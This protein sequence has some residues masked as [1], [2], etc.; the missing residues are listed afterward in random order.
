VTGANGNW[1]RQWSL[2]AA[3]A[4]AIV[5]RFGAELRAIYQ[6]RD[7]TWAP[8]FGPGVFAG[9]D[10]VLQ[11]DTRFEATRALHLRTGAL[12]D[13]IHIENSGYQPYPT[14]S[15]RK[16]SRAYLGLEARFG[17]VTVEVIEGIELDHEPYEVWFVHDKGFLHLQTTF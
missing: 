15:S 1:R 12:Y 8:P 3:L 16:E 11:L 2:E 14:W 10:R 9:I 4:R 6:S 5:P 17:R 7:E 13:R